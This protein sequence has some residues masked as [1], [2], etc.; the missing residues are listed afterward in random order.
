[1]R[2][3]LPPFA[4]SSASEKTR[5]CVEKN[6]PPM[7]AIIFP[8]RLRPGKRI[9]SI[10]RSQKLGFFRLNFVVLFS[11]SCTRGDV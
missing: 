2:T 4:Q 10:G 9:A 1:M 6:F 11:G 7:D 8:G 3:F 5:R